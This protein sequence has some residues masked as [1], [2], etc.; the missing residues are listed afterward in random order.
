[1]KETLSRLGGA[2]KSSRKPSTTNWPKAA[3]APIKRNKDH[4]QRPRYRR[5]E[6]A[7]AFIW[8]PE[9]TWYLFIP[10][11]QCRLYGFRMLF[12]VLASSSWHL[13]CIG[14]VALRGPPVRPGW[15]VGGRGNRYAS[16][17]AAQV[18][19]PRRIR[20]FDLLVAHVEG[21][22]NNRRQLERVHLRNTTKCPV[23]CGQKKLP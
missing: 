21:T 23:F 15:P 4:M 11:S 19:V 16:D 1:M 2:A 22:A 14:S 10:S 13:R 3:R 20:N 7:I 17:G 8:M 9:C 12:F 18:Q 6:R 5:T